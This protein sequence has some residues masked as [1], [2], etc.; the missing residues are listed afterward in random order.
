[1]N[2][3]KKEE[4]EKCVVCGCVTQTPIDRPVSK[5]ANY[6]IGVGEVCSK[7]LMEV[8]CNINPFGDE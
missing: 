6:V 4:F 1:M 7:C 2:K 8:Y 5:R 3:N